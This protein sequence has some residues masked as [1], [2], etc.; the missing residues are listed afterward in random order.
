M[1]GPYFFSLGKF[2]MKKLL[3]CMA[4]LGTFTLGLP[5][6]GGS[7]NESTVVPPVE[8]PT[9]SAENQSAYEQQMKGG[10]SSKPGN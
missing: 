10:G 7:S 9:M 1:F 3:I 4:F 8:G 2:E 6:C 5:G